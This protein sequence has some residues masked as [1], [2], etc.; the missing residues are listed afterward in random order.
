[1]PLTTPL[2]MPLITLKSRALL[3]QLAS[4][5]VLL[6]LTACAGTYHAYKDTLQLAFTQPADA[7]LTLAEVTAANF[8]YLY[9]THGER[10]QSVMA[11]MFIEQDQL[12]WIS[13]DDAMLITEQGRII[14]TLGFNND[15]VTLTAATA[16]PIANFNNIHSQTSWQRLVDWSAGEYGYNVTSYFEVQPGHNLQFFQH[17]I[18]V[19][20]VIEYVSYDAAANYV[21]FDQDWQNIFWFDAK[22]GALLQSQQQLAPFTEP[23]QLVFISQ[24]AREL[25]KQALAK[26]ALVENAKS[27]QPL[28]HPAA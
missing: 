26:Q 16:D 15:L 6:S 27:P 9:V 11:L 24:V 13:A 2:T 21:R 4:A 20:K 14:K 5:V 25:A 12:K 28:E 1:M 19:I 23:M 8:D 10:A 3:K 22:S 7:S 18:A 17:D